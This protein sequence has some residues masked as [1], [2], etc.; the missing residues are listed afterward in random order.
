MT[1]RRIAAAISIGALLLAGCSSTSAAGPTTGSGTPIP[2]APQ[3]D[4]ET[5]ADG[6]AIPW[7]VAQAPDGTLIFDQKAGGLSVIKNGNVTE[8]TADFNDLFSGG[9]GGLM[10][11]VLDPDFESNR[12]FYTCQGVTDPVE[13]KVVSWTMAADYSSAKRVEDPLVSGIP[14]ADG[15]RHSGCRL[16]FDADGYL[17]VGTGDTANGLLP[18]DKTSLGGKTLRVDPATGAA[19]PGN[20]FIDSSDPKEKL[21]YT[22]GHRNVQGLA[23][24]PGSGQLFSVEHGPSVDDEVNLLAAGANYGWNPTTDGTSSY[25]ESVPMTDTTISGAVPAVWSSGDPTIA[26][27]GGTFIEGSGW[28]EFDGLLAVGVLKGQGIELMRFDAAGTLQSAT[29][30]PEFEQ[31]YGRIRTTQMGT[32][33]SLYV[34]TSNGDGDKILKV[35]PKG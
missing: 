15:G 1:R 10:G 23:L 28:G 22:W 25:D 7:D 16:R 11:L 13:N 2:A 34:T 29:R 21:V 12:R 19:A 18:Q 33:G 6:L 35:T 27:S 14:R 31:T 26:P 20:P 17:N 9:E 24:R 5:V 8:V 4:I 3:V 30:W 32:D